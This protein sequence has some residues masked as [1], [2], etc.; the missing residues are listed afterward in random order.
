ML[1]LWQSF[2]EL[3][4]NVVYTRKELL[5][6]IIQTLQMVGWTTLYSAGF[7]VIFGVTLVVTQKDGILE[8]KPVYQIL[9]KLI[10]VFRSIP[11]VI[12]V[13]LL[14]KLTRMISGTSIG[15][16]GMIFPMI[17]ATVP[18]LSRQI[19]SALVEI[20]PGM[21]EAA[22]SMGCSPLDIIWRV[23]LRE[24]LP[25][26]IRGATITIVNVVTI[27][28]MA[29]YVGGGG[30][31]DYAMRYGWQRALT[32]VTIVTIIIILAIVT[33]IQTLGGFLA[34]KLTH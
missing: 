19:H 31:G 32:D 9:D 23:Y 16:K 7:G 30:L 27:T 18:F 11:F 21:I 1:E 25:G 10:N 22:Q 26:M 20:D 24:G 12:L 29:G 13:A 33:I 28:A 17:V 14:I 8:C 5:K 15:T 34:R 3:I 2:L 4:P 6:C